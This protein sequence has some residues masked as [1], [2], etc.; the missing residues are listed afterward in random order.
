MEPIP[1]RFRGDGIEVDRLGV[2][3]FTPMLGIHQ[4]FILFFS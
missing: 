1:Q 4:E 2:S 3:D